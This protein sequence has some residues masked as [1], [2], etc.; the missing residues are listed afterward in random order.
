MTEDRDMFRHFFDGK[1][2]EFMVF[3]DSSDFRTAS[4]CIVEFYELFWDLNL[5]KLKSYKAMKHFI[6]YLWFYHYENK[7]QNRNIYFFIMD[8]SFLFIKAKTLIASKSFNYGISD[9]NLIYEII[10][11]FAF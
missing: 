8:S 9:F 10:L 1:K 2:L 5:V 4:Y 11:C 3:V 7:T 6:S